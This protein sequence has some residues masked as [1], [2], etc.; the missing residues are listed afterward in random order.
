[1]STG[2]LEQTTVGAESASDTE[3]A[4][5]DDFETGG[6]PRGRPAFPGLPSRPAP[7]AE[8]AARQQKQSLL[9]FDLETAPDYSRAELFGLDPL[10][11]PRPESGVSECGGPS[12]V[13]DFLK[14]SLDQIN[15][16]LKRLNPCDAW[17]DLLA[18]AEQKRE[19]PRVGLL[20]AVKSAREA[21]N[22]AVN[23]VAERKKLLSVTPEF[24]RIVAM[25]WA[26][27]DGDQP[28]S[29][30]AI[31][32]DHEIQDDLERR[33]LE[34]FWSMATDCDRLV[35]YN[36]LG[37]DLPV[38]FVRSLI[39]GVPA[40]KRIDLRPWGTDVIDLMERRFTK[41]KAM[42]LK[43][44]ARVLG[45]PVA[46]GDVDGSQVAELA[47]VNPGLVATYVQSDVAVTRDL[48]RLY[49]G[50]FC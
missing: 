14:L 21:R 37:F 26:F 22:V 11:T 29:L 16:E 6:F 12:A 17:L 10:P 13:E 15:G 30:L 7:Q 40:S 4:S 5:L 43:D 8:K 33:L 39:M 45:I 23:A 41:S 34:S 42:K 20:G 38:I 25:G 46:A 2:T 50:Y 9:F 1:M 44:L 48:F 18:D 49:E 3:F 19:K 32:A 24:C 35:G 36:V 28:E 31:D 27:S 47:E